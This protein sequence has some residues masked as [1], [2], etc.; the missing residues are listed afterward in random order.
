M[1]SVLYHTDDGKPPIEYDVIKDN[2]DGTF[3]IGK[4]TVLVIGK[5]SL[6]LDGAPGTCTDPSV[7][8]VDTKKKS[9]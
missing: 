1:K 8:P 2:G 9:K 6:S 4:G 7:K 3:D 5:C